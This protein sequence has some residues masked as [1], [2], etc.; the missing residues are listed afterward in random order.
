MSDI[1]AYT[2]A[3]E[4]AQLDDVKQRLSLTRFPDELDEAG[5][6]MGAPLQDVKRLAEYWQSGYDWRAAEKKLNELPHF[7]TPIQCDGFAPLNIHFVHRPSQVKEAIPLLFIHGWPGHFNEVAKIL[8]PLGDGDGVNT[9][10]FHVVAPSLPNFGF[11]EAPRKR[12]FAMEQYA[13]T[14][15]RLMQKLGYDEYVTQGGMPE[16][17]V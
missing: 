15:N 2:I 7:V 3:V 4:D 16:D 5:W 13:E 1:K 11:S 12:G 14:L 17:T 8:G 6:D 10:A 9:P